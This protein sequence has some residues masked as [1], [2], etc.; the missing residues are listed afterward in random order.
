MR[1]LL[2]ALCALFLGGCGQRAT[3]APAADPHATSIATGE[4]I[5]GATVAAQE[6]IIA[7]LRSDL[8]AAEGNLVLLKNKARAATLYWTAG[9]LGFVALIAGIGSFLPALAILAK[10]LRVVAVVCGAAATVA[11]FLGDHAADL[12]V[13]GGALILGAAAY[14]IWGPGGVRVWLEAHWQAIRGWVATSAL[15]HDIAPPSAAQVDRASLATQ[16]PAVQAI[17]TPLIAAAKQ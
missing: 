10:N 6:K 4:L 9:V 11:I 16:S 1:Y 8:A 3:P 14:V 2:I 17:N 15:L 12:P 7:N 13:Y 5:K